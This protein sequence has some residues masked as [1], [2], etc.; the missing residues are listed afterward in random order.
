MWSRCSEII[1][2]TERPPGDILN[3]VD[4]NTLARRLAEVRSRIALAC[5][6]SGRSVSDVTLVTVTK[7]V[8]AQLI[9]DAVTAGV[10]DVGENR[11]QETRAKG[12]LL[13]DLRECV[14]WHMIGKLQTNKVKAAL[15]L[16]DIIHSVD[17]LHLAEEIS[18]RAL[19]PVPVFLEVNV[20]GEQTKSGFSPS[21]IP[22]AYKQI[23]CLPNIEVRG[24]MTVPPMTPHSEDVRPFFR[25]LREQAESL[26]LAEL[27]MGMTDDFEVAIE[28]GST[29][30][31]I[32]RAIFGE[33]QDA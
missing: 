1:R 16:F 32:G 17:S 33:R 14:T 10:S 6:R 26:G 22:D 30:V 23:A 3:G 19:Q 12:R 18:R 27:S 24:L 29:H 7:G 5:S 9:R 13:E 8:S 20:A 25:Q 15:E 28:E 21:E 11:I 2:Q 31:R 4:A